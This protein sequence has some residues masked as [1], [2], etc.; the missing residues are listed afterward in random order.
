MA[1]GE[2]R[3]HPNHLAQAGLGHRHMQ[4]RERQSQMEIM[5]TNHAWYFSYPSMQI[6]FDFVWSPMGAQRKARQFGF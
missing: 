4:W 2:I 3:F 6:Q 5:S 1:H